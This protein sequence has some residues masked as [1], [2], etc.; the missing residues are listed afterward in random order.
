MGKSHKHYLSERK[1]NKNLTYSVIPLINFKN[2]KKQY[3]IIE[4]QN[5]GFSGKKVGNVLLLNFIVDC[6]MSLYESRYRL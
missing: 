5:N 3:I 4:V 2:W 1:L 6:C